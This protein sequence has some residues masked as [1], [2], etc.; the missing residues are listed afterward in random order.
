M[1]SGEG[2][3]MVTSNDKIFEKAF[4]LENRSSCRRFWN[5]RY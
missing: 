1:Q 4:Y 5:N 2:G 3:V